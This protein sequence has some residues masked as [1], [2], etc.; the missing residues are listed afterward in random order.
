MPHLSTIVADINT[1]L[2]ANPFIGEKYQHAQWNGIADSQLRTADNKTFPVIVTSAGEET[3]LTIDD[4]F[5][6]QFYHCLDRLNYSIAPNSDYGKPGTVMQ[7]DAG[8]QLIFLGD[9]Q[10]SGLR[11]EDLIAALALWL[12]KE[13]TIS[14]LG[15]CVIVMGDVNI[16]SM[17]VFANQ[18][19]GS[20]YKLKPSQFMASISYRIISTYNKTCYTIC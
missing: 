10:S 14:Q 9:R 16:D 11:P 6:L 12:P 4:T 15:S 5:N 13:L 17:K 3:S 7:E 2:Q 18:Y 20:E 8:M 19:P 1:A